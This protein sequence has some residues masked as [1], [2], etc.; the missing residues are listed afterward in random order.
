M[1]I[2]GAGRIGREV[3]RISHCFGMTVWALARDN[4]PARTRVTDIDRFFSRPELS[5]MLA[6]AD[7]VVL[8]VPHTPETEGLI[9]EHELAACK[10][11]TVLINIA[12]GAVIEEAA[13]IEALQKNLI[14]FAALDV[15]E[16]EPLS[17]DSPL[18]DLPNVLISPHS[19]S[20]ADT[21]NTKLTQRFI[22]NLDHYLAG[23]V[24][25]MEPILDKQRLY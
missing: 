23:K 21:E 18:W 24:D 2:I 6:A 25:R 7:C 5:V 8:C 3:A 9:G 16:A 4:S 14:A 13:L 10:A 1:A 19:A 11:G 15:V 12:R 17:A 22:A 20:T